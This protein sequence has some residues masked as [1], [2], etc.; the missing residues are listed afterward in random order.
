MQIPLFI[1]PLFANTDSGDDSIVENSPVFNEEDLLVSIFGNS[2]TEVKLSQNATA[3]AQLDANLW[4]RAIVDSSL[5]I[6]PR[7]NFDI[8][9]EDETSLKS[10]SID[11][12]KDEAV[13]KSEIF[14]KNRYAEGINIKHPGRSFR[15]LFP[16]LDKTN[17]FYG[18]PIYFPDAIKAMS[19]ICVFD[20][21]KSKTLSLKNIEFLPQGAINASL[22][23]GKIKGTA[24]IEYLP[25]LNIAAPQFLQDRANTINPKVDLPFVPSKASLRIPFDVNSH[26]TSTLTTKVLFEKNTGDYKKE[27]RKINFSAK[28]K[29]LSGK[30]I[31]YFSR[32]F[33][34]HDFGEDYFCVVFTAWPENSYSYGK[35]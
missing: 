9:K 27:I 30:E 29:I 6:I 22:Y 4:K 20:A 15:A 26:I 18:A 3:N 13:I 11:Q 1:Q 19:Y 24:E 33:P 32:S 8:I 5:K 34:N 2:G 10:I 12:N 31:S 28:S 35:Q 25:G 17:V 14:D 16:T 23:T 21:D 7:I